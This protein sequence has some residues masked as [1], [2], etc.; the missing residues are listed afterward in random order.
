M[1][2]KELWIRNISK[3]DVMIHDLGVKIKKGCVANI[4]RSNPYLTAEQVKHSYQQ[5]A[6][7]EKIKSKLLIRINKKP[8]PDPA[9]LIEQAKEGQTA[10][11]RKTKSSVIIETNQPDAEEED[12]GFADYGVND[13]VEYEKNLDSVTVK[14][15]AEPEAPTESPS[16]DPEELYV[17]TFSKASHPMG[18]IAKASGKPYTVSQDGSES[19]PPEPVVETPKEPEKPKGAKTKVTADEKKETAVVQEE[20]KMVVASKKSTIVMEVKDNE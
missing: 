11:V 9:K 4:F 15:K 20:E 14:S 13:V 16:Q 5:G 1:S 12:F 17:D 3:K 8:E 18:A 2:E 19:L 6:L 10:V 7:H